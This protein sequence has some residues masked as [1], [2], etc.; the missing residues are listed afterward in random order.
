MAREEH[1]LGRRERTGLLLRRIRRFVRFLPRIVTFRRR[2]VR[3]YLFRSRLIKA[4]LASHRVAK[5]QLGS[6]G[7]VMEGWLNTSLRPRSADI[8]FLDVTEPFPFDD[9]VFDYV[10]SEHLI[11]HLP[12][13]DGTLMLSECFRVLKPGGHI[14]LSTPDLAVVAGLVCQGDEKSASYVR[15]I[16]SSFP[17]DVPRESPAMV[18]NNLFYNWGHRFLYDFAALKAALEEAGFVGVRACE[19]G[20]SDDPALHGVEQHV[21]TTALDEE[22]SRFEALVV[23]AARPTA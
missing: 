2:R 5:L 17:G 10:L 16:A 20:K 1:W 4:Y 8:V 12:F 14:R 23:E 19:A 21:G 15:W 22:M 3:G 6:A 13:N 11:E 9:A 7:N 18:A